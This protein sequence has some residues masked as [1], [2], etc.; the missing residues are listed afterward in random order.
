MANRQR[1]KH[2]L[3]DHIRTRALRDA[4]PLARGRL[5]DIGCGIKPYRE[6]FGPYVDEHVGVDHPSSLHGADAV[7]LTAT[8]YDI[9]VP[10]GSFDTV[11]STA[12]LEHLEEPLEGLEEARRVLRDGGLAIYTVP[13]IWH[14]HEAPRDFYRYSRYGLQHLFDRAGFDVVEIRALSG[15]WVTFGQLFVYYLYRFRRG[16][17][18]IVP[19]IEILG[20]AIQALALALDRIDRAEQWTWMYLVVARARARSG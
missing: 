10:D 5:L 6:L 13:F 9:P 15:F 3:V 4:A 16:P 2:L 17:L 20:V 8:A 14:V 12:V 19:L 11:L 18:R 7:D 1:L